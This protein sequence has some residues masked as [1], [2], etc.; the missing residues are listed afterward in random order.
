MN[1]QADKVSNFPYDGFPTVPSL[2]TDMSA[3]IGAFATALAKAQGEMTFAH[4]DSENPFFKSSYADLAS[5]WDAIR[6]PLSKHEIAVVQLPGPMTDGVALTTKL[7]H[8][9]GEWVESYAEMVM[10]K[11]DAHAYGSALT[12][13]RRYS[14][15][16][17]AG[18]TQADDDGNVA[19]ESAFSSTAARSKVRNKLLA[20]AKDGEDDKVAEIRGELT[21][22]QKA[23]LM[24]VIAKP[25]QKL[26]AESL[27]RTKEAA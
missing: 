1:A 9:S 15:T 8:K 27:E 24:S 20:A 23:E 26:I 11:N 18:I 17:M 14:L 13:L 25:D 7:I 21:N 10:A 2:K 3:S 6:G 5:V 19:S 12:Y 4:K 16:A 22:D